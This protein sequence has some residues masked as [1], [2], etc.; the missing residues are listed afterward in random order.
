MAL[1]AAV[2]DVA[3]PAWHAPA[4]GVY[5][6]WRDAGF[7]IGALVSGAVADLFGL[8]AAIWTVAVITAAGAGIVAV[9]MYETHG[10]SNIY[11]MSLR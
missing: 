8:A 3:R 5:R 2:G 6:L 10:R 9:R 7:V 4:V 1:L 11:K